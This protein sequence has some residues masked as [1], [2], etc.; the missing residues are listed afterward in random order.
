MAKK[1]YATQLLKIVRN[2]TEEISFEEAALALKAANPQ[3]HDTKKNTM[4]IKKILDRFAENGLVRKTNSGMY[5]HN[6]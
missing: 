3:L 2:A 1:T 4:G 5:K 6:V